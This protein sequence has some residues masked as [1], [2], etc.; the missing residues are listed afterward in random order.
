[1]KTTLLVVT[2]FVFSC[3][4][5]HSPAS[6]RQLDYSTVYLMQWVADCAARLHQILTQQGLHPML[7]QRE[8]GLQCACV[9]D[10]FRRNYTRSEVESMTME[11]R[12][13]FA[14]HFAKQCLG[15]RDDSSK[16]SKSIRPA[17]RIYQAG[18]RVPIAGI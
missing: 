10:G 14:E 5:P 17:S 6:E 15:I 12:G 18:R 16:Q 13:L 7:S 9:I 8:A 2:F 1:M 3:F 11:D 4:P